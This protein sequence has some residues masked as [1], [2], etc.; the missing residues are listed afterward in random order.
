MSGRHQAP[1]HLLPSEPTP[2]LA[3]ARPLLAATLLLGM[4]GVV[5][6]RPGIGSGGDDSTSPTSVVPAAEGEA[7]SLCTRASLED[8]AGLVLV[9]GLPGVTTADDPL[10]DRLAAA[11]VGGVMLRDGNIVDE[12][13]VADLVDGLRARLGSHLLVAVDDEGGRV[14]SMGA[15]GQSL[16]SARRLGQQ[17]EDAAREAGSALGELAASVGIDWVFAPVA[18]LD[19]G[20]SSGVIGDRSFGRDPQEVAEAAGAFADGIRSTGV[21]VTAKH[22]PGHGGEGDPHAGD[23]VDTTPLDVLRA[24]DLVPF[25]ALVDDGAEAVM[26]GHVSYSAV[27]DDLPAS[28]QPGAYQLLRDLGFH[29]VAITDALG[30]GAVHARFG[31]DVAPAMAVA[32]GADAVL[33]NQGEEVDVLHAGLV[34]AVQEGRLDEGRLD[35][36]VRRMLALR[37]ESPDGVVCPAA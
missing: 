2:R 1:K 37:G 21:A 20:P 8:R 26:V 10:V 19:D 29:G 12:E 33:V 36:A 5:L 9:V 16:T 3:W 15:L 18:D 28:L 11:G 23:T 27:W 34:D 30:M 17:G 14:S 7:I 25:G 32:A 35:E 31:F 4:A 6:L 24:E 13:Q 22:F